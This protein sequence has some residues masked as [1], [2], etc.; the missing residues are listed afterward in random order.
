MADWPI[1]SL[2]GVTPLEAAHIPAIERL[3][4]KGTAGLVKTIPEGL[5]CGSDV[6]NMSA[7]GL[8]PHVLSGRA[9]LE[10]AALGLTLQPNDMA[11]RCNLVTLAGEGEYEAGIM[12][13]Y[14]ADE[15]STAESAQ[16]VQ[17][18]DGMLAGMGLSPRIRLHA[19]ISYRHCLVIK[20]CMAAM[21][22]T[23]PHDISGK[24]IA[25][26]LPKGEDADLLTL[27]MNKSRALLEGHPVNVARRKKGLRPANSMWFWGQGHPPAI[28][29]YQ[30]VYGLSGAMI[31]AVDLLKGIGSLCGMRVME[32]PGA[33]GTLHTNYAGKVAAAK[34]AYRDGADFV[35]VHLEGPD[36][37]GHRKEV[38]NKI[39]AIEQIDEKIVA[40][41]VAF[42]QEEGD[43]RVLVM[44][45]HP[46]PLA[47]GTHTGDPVPFVLYDSR[48]PGQAPVKRYTERHAAETGVY[49]ETGA[50]LMARFTGK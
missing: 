13:D 16:L 6:G 2:G 36:E 41:L 49:F 47:I 42:L 7:L 11:L 27:I 19:G 20:N 29:H 18:L 39:S 35:Y 48:T 30:E 23:P 12:E 9:P 24:P 50:Q 38:E 8:D 1:E 28:P 43:F 14:S 45:D 26:H 25:A 10:A 22:L 3:A 37:C 40:P 46:T 17:A 15:I 33:T 21:Q 34:E 31:S 4:A 44:P 5:A 32:V